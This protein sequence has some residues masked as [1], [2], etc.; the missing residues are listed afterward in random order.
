VRQEF[1]GLMLA[2]FANRGLMH[3]AALEVSEDPDWLS[4]VHSVRVI[5]RRLPRFV[6]IPPSAE[7]SIS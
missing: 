2:H 4:F 7:K 3:E 6:A 1:Y 5:R